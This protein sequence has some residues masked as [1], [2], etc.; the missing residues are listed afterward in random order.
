MDNEDVVSCSTGRSTGRPTGRL[1]WNW[2]TVLT[3]QDVPVGVSLDLSSGVA[4]LTEV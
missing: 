2:V 3:R 1:S 4:R